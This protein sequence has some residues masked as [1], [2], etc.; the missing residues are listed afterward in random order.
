M[1]TSSTT[2]KKPHLNHRTEG[3]FPLHMKQLNAGASGRYLNNI[4]TLDLMTIHFN[5]SPGHTTLENLEDSGNTLY[6][7]QKVII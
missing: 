3:N 1:T 4:F 5:A 7:N 6:S 2:V